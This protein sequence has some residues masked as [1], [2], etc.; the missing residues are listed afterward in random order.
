MGGIKRWTIRVQKSAFSFK[1][2]IK[3]SGGKWIKK[4]LM[5]CLVLF[6]KKLFIMRYPFLHS[7]KCICLYDL[8]VLLAI[9]K[10]FFILTV[11]F[12][13]W[14]KLIFSFS[15]KMT[16]RTVKSDLSLL[17]DL[18]SNSGDYQ[19]CVDPNHPSFTR[20][21]P[22]HLYPSHLQLHPTPYLCHIFTG[23]VLGET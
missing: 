12:F 1:T 16:F 23:T 20:R 19:C 4:I 2:L 10:A 14:I 13:Y 9:Y 8:F 15:I 3:F 22:L 5:E 11:S 6:C 7:R 17:Q 21:W 18:H